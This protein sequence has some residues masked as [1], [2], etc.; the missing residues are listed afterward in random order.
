MAAID[1]REGNMS[2]KWGFV[3][4]TGKIITACQF[5]DADSF[6]QGLAAVK[7]GGKWGWIDRTGQARIP[8]EFEAVG[9]FGDGR[10]PVKRGEKWGYV[11]RTGRLVIDYLYGEW[12]NFENGH[13]RVRRDGNSLYIDINGNPSTPQE[14]RPRVLMVGHDVGARFGFEDNTGRILVNPQFDVVS[15]FSESEVAVVSTG[16]SSG[17]ID[18]HGLWIVPLQLRYH[19]RAF[20]KKP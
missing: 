18:K 14:S 7:K 5:D 10:A 3:G 15:D 20:P 4:P 17:I 19:F 13:A 2:S 8:M 11:D 16:R 6:H 9:S 12:G 1:R